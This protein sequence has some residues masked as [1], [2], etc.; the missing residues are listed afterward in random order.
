MML[1][2]VQ[3]CGGQHAGLAQAAAEC[4][5]PAPCLREVRQRAEQQGACRRAEALAEAEAHAV[6]AGHG[7][8][9]AHAEPHDRIRKPRTVEM[10]G[11]TARLR[12]R[13]RLG[14]IGRR[15]HLAADRVLE[16]EQVRAREVDIVRL[17]RGGEIGERDRT[18]RLIR[19]RL[20]L[21]AAQHGSAALLV[22][23]G[24]RILADEVFVAAL[25]V[26][27]QRREIALRAGREPECGLEAE[28][29]CR[30]SLQAVDGRVVAIDVIA[31]L[32]SRHGCTH[33]GGRARHGIAAQ[34][35]HRDSP[36]ARV[37]GSSL[38]DASIEA[39]G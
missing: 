18:V 8:V 17:D 15:Q 21:D 39:T 3:P 9:L 11:K 14:D 22:L 26:A 13:R 31:D 12:E 1:E 20:R 37:A 7:L 16:R 32:G 30:N 2:R 19:D 34:I 5:A 24:M 38:A 4:L 10:R 33:G 6:E 23:V 35:D 28:A 27:H 36:G 29:L 25:A